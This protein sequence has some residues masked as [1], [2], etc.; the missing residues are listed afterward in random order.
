[1]RVVGF[2]FTKIS[3]EKLKDEAKSIK[4]NTDISVSEIKRSASRLFKTNEELL[5]A[6]FSY[7]VNYEPDF[8]EVGFAGRVLLAVEPKMA[9]EVLKQW[10]NKKMP[11]DFK[12]LLFNMILRKSALKALNLEDELNLPLHLPLPS[13]KKSEDTNK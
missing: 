1:M 5:E 12:F 3:I 4:I 8:V 6:K 10:K 11:E 2:N 7:K 9:K 13:L